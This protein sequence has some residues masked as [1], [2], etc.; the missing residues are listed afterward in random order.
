MNTLVYDVEVLRGPDEVDGGWDNPF[1]M[2]F[3]TAVVYDYCR[4]VYEFYGEGERRK[5]VNRLGG[6]RVVSF[7][8]VKFDANV[9]CSRNEVRPSWEDYDLLLEVIKSKFG[10]TTVQEAERK[11]GDKA[12]HDG[13]FGLDGLAEGTLGLRK[14]G[15][16]AKAP[17]LIRNGKWAEVYAY[18]LND[19][20]LTRMLYDFVSQYGYVVDRRG[21]KIVVDKRT[22]GWRP[23]SK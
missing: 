13:T 5:L 16:G 3:G 23:M 11:L 18:N 8:G 2:G 7:N 21:R 4:D 12:I 14:T 17:E 1:G 19:V 22:N 20:R 10:L 6:N 15:H 9:I